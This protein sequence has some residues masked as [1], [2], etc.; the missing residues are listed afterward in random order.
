MQELARMECVLALQTTGIA[1]YSPKDDF[2]YVPGQTSAS[3]VFEENMRKILDCDFML[4]STEGRDMGTL[5]ECGFAYSNGIPIVY[6]FKGDGPFN[7]MLSESGHRVIRNPLELI[8]VL[9]EIKATETVVKV[10][11]FGDKE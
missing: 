4:A 1:T 9:R 2:L 5:F 7:I 6:Y 11:Y 8:E 10:P 3:E